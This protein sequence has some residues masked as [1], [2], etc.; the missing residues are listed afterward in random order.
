[1][2]GK[3]FKWLAVVV[4]SSLI[5]TGCQIGRIVYRPSIPPSFRSFGDYHVVLAADFVQQTPPATPRPKEDESA[6]EIDQ[7]DDKAPV[8][9]DP[10]SEPAAQPRYTSPGPQYQPLPVSAIVLAAFGLS[11]VAGAGKEA[12]ESQIG[13]APAAVIGRPGLSAPPPTI[14]NAIVGRPGLQQGFAASLGPVSDPNIFTPRLNPLSG[15]NGRC[16]ELVGA[17]FF[18]R[19]RAACESRFRR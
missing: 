5:S 8:V 13:G 1:M 2:S 17:G 19:N 6:D 4:A 15:P 9:A 3:N 16:Q 12:A 14:A 18:N 11:D 7:E 10:D